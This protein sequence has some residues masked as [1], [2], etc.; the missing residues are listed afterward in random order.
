ML[1]DAFQGPTKNSC[2][3]C[4]DRVIKKLNTSASKWGG[5][6]SK[7]PNMTRLFTFVLFAITAPGLMNF[8]F[9]TEPTVLY[10]PEQSTERKAWEKYVSEED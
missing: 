5:W 1:A 4:A 3:S 9:E 8:E 10:C 7:W 2:Q 6:V